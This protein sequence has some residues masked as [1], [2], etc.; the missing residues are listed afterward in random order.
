MISNPS[1][2]LRKVLQVGISCF[3]FWRADQDEE[4]RE[5]ERREEERRREEQRR[6][7]EREQS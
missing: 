2:S 7:L 5:R 4:R 1:T 3:A 6:R